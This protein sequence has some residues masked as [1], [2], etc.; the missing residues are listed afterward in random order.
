MVGA[1]PGVYGHYKGGRYRVLFTVTESTNV[2]EG[3][4]VVIYVSLTNGNIFCRD[5]AEFSEPIIW[6]DGVTRPRFL[7]ES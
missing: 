2:R 4:M 3:A 5:L 6:P 1:E 7:R